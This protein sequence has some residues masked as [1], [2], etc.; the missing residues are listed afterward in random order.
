MR[1]IITV[2][3]EFAS[4]GKEFGA[5]L[6]QELGLP[7]YD[8]EI[9]L[10]IAQK[11]KLSEEHIKEVSERRPQDYYPVTFGHT[12][13]YLDNYYPIHHVNDI[14]VEQTAIIK[15]MADKSDCI[16][17]GRCADY[18]LKDYS[19]LRIFVYADTESKIKR[20]QDRAPEGE[21]LS[22][23][24]IIKQINRVNKGRAQYY[25]YYTG[26]KWGDKLNYDLC[27]N[28]SNYDIRALAKSI[29]DL[30]RAKDN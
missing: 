20:C 7:Y 5:Y 13:I 6:A 11:T 4:G 12:F 10:A 17:I 9:I 23:K 30:V 8:K 22:D 19:P 15:E 27:I 16:I 2:S 29:A 3:R 28:T 26:L 24:E 25:E 21:N 14:Y 1:K 18:V